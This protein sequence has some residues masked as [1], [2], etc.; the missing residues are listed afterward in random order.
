MRRK[1]HTCVLEWYLCDLYT[2]TGL[3]VHDLQ[4]L[5]HLAQ[6]NMCYLDDLH[7]LTEMR[8]VRFAGSV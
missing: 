5:H 1:F 3:D 7:T 2:F 4:D 6:W 8:F